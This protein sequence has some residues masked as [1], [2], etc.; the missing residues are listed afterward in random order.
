[1]NSGEAW[2]HKAKLR[3]V[4]NITTKQHPTIVCVYDQLT[5]DGNKKNGQPA[6]TGGMDERTGKPAVVLGRSSSLYLYDSIDE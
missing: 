4:H 1:M 6:T 5:V 2:F 3:E